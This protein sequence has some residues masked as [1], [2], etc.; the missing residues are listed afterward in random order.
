[1]LKQ[2]ARYAV[3]RW[4]PGLVN[5]AAIALYTRLLTK[6]AYGAYAIAVAWVAL[7]NAL[8]FQWLRSGVRRF[9][10]VYRTDRPGF[11][12]TVGRAFLGLCLLIVVLGI[13]VLLLQSTA[14]RRWLVLAGLLLLVSQ[15]WL[16]LNLDMVLAE[17]RPWRFGAAMLV[18]SMISL[19][20]GAA[21]AAAGIGAVGVVAGISVGYVASGA[22]LGLLQ[23]RGVGTGRPRPEVRA[24][25]LGYGLPL[26]LTFGLDFI[27]NSSDRLLL[28]WL[29]GTDAVGAYAASYDLSQQGMT[30]LMM[31][32]NLGAFPMAVRALELGGLSAAQAQL[33]RHAV[34]LMGLALPAT[35]GLVL[36]APNIAY[37]VL[38]GAFRTAGEQLI[39]IVAI[40]AFL[41]GLKAY[42]FD[43]AFQL[44]NST[45]PLVWSS[46][47][48]AVANVG[49]NLVLIPR[50]G[51]I[52][53]AWATLAA[54]GLGLGLSIA[55]GR[56]GIALP[57]PWKA[58]GGLAF[59]SSVMGG[60]LWTMR[61][62]RGLPGLTLQVAAGGLA[63]G[64][65]TL[66]LDIGLLR[67]LL[68]ARYA[69]R[70][71]P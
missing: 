25:L 58:W 43:L 57:V 18:R 15:A 40:A 69:A 11:L 68:L 71:R 34:V 51:A 24:A 13:A 19:A 66:L 16:D 20:A 48:A 53:A 50:Y 6:D 36:L 31:T 60:V 33:R 14:T 44:G 64:A 26:T 46:G 4:L 1:M 17:V 49:L 54:F 7:V 28:G 8:G 62:M 37:V 39:P 70:A 52:G 3:A 38:G 9:L 63:F 23:W 41:A 29:A 47:S 65:V 27:V 22:W 21:L 2:T 32:V 67:T 59:A 61:A 10:V 56:R 12:A 35:V 45:V 30:A 5:F 42:Y 55:L